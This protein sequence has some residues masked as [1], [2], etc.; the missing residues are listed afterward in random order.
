VGIETEGE[1]D[2]EK[3]SRWFGRLLR[4]QGT[5][6]FRMKGVFAV[7]GQDKRTVFQGVHML[8]DSKPGEPWG[9]RLRRNS[10]VF[11]GR[12][13]DREELNR[14]FRSCLA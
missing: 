5:D 11:I 8:L 9:D 4:E 13:L 3:L 2:G 6:I 14:G 7:R 1:C 10:L 12:N